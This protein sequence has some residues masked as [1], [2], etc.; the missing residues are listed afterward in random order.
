[1]RFSRRR[2]LGTTLT[3]LA[4]A[5]ILNAKPVLRN[6]LGANSKVQIAAIGL[7]N[8]GEANWQGVGHETITA[9]CDVDLNMAGK[10][11]EKYPSAF[12]NQD[13]RKVLEQKN[14]D[15]VVVATPDHTH[16]CIAAAALRL[17]K[18]VY[19]EKPLC[20]SVQEVRTLQS[21]AAEKK[22]ITQMGTQIH[23]GEN[24]RRVVE[25]IQAN[26]IG[27]VKEVHVWCNVKYG[28]KTKPAKYPAT[29]QSLNYDLWLGPASFMPYHTEWVPFGWRNWWH[30]GGG[31]MSDFGCHYMDLPFWALGLKEPTSVET[32]GPEVLPD[33]PPT[34]LQ[35]KYQFP[36]KN[37]SIPFTWYHGD[38][39]PDLLKDL[40][41]TVKP[42]GSGVMFVGSKGQ[43][44]ANYDAHML[45]PVETFADYKR[46]EKSIPKT[47]GHHREWTEAIKGNGKTTC[48]F[49]Y[50]GG[51]STSVILGNVAYRS[52]GKLTWDMVTGTTKEA[53]AKEF[54][55]REYRKGW[56]L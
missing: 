50:S 37:G 14:I 39:K 38:K 34:S 21:L 42:Y 49:D 31:T 51:L 20:F 15:A 45:L 48:N 11:R 36:Y 56:E 4:S 40:P 16:A 6:V 30:F 2:F 54:L 9:L 44:M 43:L 53:S 13:Y 18:H 27:D 25:L 17:G 46:P 3:G 5:S 52:G 47:I 1:M 35:V 41:T 28:G 19:C 12:F 24:Y 10:A 8:R 32:N 23:A 33:S 22:V 29:P 55:H 7:G 26:A